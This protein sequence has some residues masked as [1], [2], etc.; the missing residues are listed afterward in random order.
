MSLLQDITVV[1]L[2]QAVAAPLTSRHLADW[3]ARVIKV[4]RPGC[5]DFAR[6]YDK[7]V[8]GLSSHFVWLN[9]SK[10]SLT[11]DM[12]TDGG[13]K[14]FSRLLGKAD[15]FIQNLAPGAVDRLGFGTDRVHAAHPELIVCNISGY[16]DDGP[17]RD[18]KAYD[19]LVQAEAGLLSITGTA[20]TPS[21]PGISIA[22]IAAGM[23]AYSGVLAALL[24]RMQ[25]G[26]GSIVDVSL[27]DAMAEWMSYPA[28]FTGYG[29]AAPMR[30]GAHHATIAPY[31]P[32]TTADGRTV[33]IG[34]QNER[35]WVRF[36]G[37]VLQRPELIDD[38]R[39]RG[40]HARIEHRAALEKC[41]R[42]VLDAVD[43]HEL[44]R[45]LEEAKIA[46]GHMN[47][48]QELFEH[49]QLSERNRWQEIG[50][51]AGPL[52]VVLPPVQI[53][54]ET[55][56]MEAIPD[57]GEHTTKILQSLGYSQDEIKRFEDLGVV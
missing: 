9:R 55:V 8:K 51:P 42:T 29:G 38:A 44:I 47:N 45:R 48:M 25:T 11:L 18:R 37:T 14:V 46:Y 20:D 21:K 41:M 27:F 28:Y 56:Q 4:E 3:G 7:T 5:G 26:R 36:C 24:R 43:S 30:S 40:N 52:R 15:V 49:P 10:Q 32:V 19:L 2:E 22:D 12:K 57:V 1:A 54:G 16:G 53:E 13:R 33:V 17:Y 31:G 6:G 50:S 34:L 35:E 39:F 23:Y